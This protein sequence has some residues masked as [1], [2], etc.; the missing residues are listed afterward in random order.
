MPGHVS[1]DM[2]KGL[3]VTDMFR[4]ALDSGHIWPAFQP[5]IDI[6][7]GSLSCFE[8][9]ARW[10]DPEHGDISPQTFIPVLEAQGLIDTLL[11]RLMHEACSTAAEWPGNFRL[12][13][14]VSPAQL[15]GKNLTPRI[16]EASAISGFPADRLEIEVTE[17][18]LLSNADLAYTTLRELYDIGVTIAVD[19]FGT[20]YSSLAR[21]EEFPFH[22]LKIDKQ[23][24]SLLNQSASKRR[25]A[26]AIIGLGQSL[27]MTIVAEGVE[28]PEEEAILR[29]LGCNLGQGWLYG[30]PVKAEKARAFAGEPDAE[31]A[32]TV[33]LDSSPFQQLHQLATLYRQAPVG[34]AFV[35]M[36]YRHVRANDRFAS[37]HGLSADEL[38]GR[39]IG[40]IMQGETLERARHVLDTSAFT[41][42][43]LKE[44]Y[45][46]NGQENLVLCNRVVDS[47]NELIGFSIVS[48]DITEQNRLARQLAMKV[49]NIRHASELH[50]DIVWAADP[51][52][53]FNY[54]GP[55]FEDVP[56]ETMRERIDRW[57]G[58]MHPD[59]V[60]AVKRQ[61]FR[62]VQTGEDHEAE[63]RARGPDGAYRWIRSR[64]R[65]RRAADGTI[66]QWHGI[67]SDITEIRQLREKLARYSGIAASDAVPEPAS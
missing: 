61:W 60:E 59:D 16:L 33:H 31:A 5:I 53:V 62:R 18:S 27:S 14:N 47:G 7:T 55:G 43:P 36:N 22:K 42:A 67:S 66:V 9:L 6:R 12:A 58:R 10:S 15:A 35:D 26:A 23:F 1:G 28:T 45:F 11:D 46:M 51:D 54:I 65:A 40:D 44:Q 13:F 17:T 2:A 8:V 37:M 30:R 32:R 52:G 25:I 38:V 56:G 41:D 29:E 39:A 49:A 48:I 63:F 21:L 24:V 19:D 20:G 64:A 34:L 57:L 3:P 4:H 50:M